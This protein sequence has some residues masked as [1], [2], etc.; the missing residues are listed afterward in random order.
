MVITSTHS[1]TRIRRGEIRDLPH[2][3]VF[4]TW[5]GLIHHYLS[6]KALFAP[7]GAVIARYGEELLGYFLGLLAR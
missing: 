7:E 3:L 4:N 1:S 6:N 5:I 2:H